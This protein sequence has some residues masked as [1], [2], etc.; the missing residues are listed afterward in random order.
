MFFLY[1]NKTNFI[2]YITILYIKLGNIYIKLHQNRKECIGIR[3]N[4]KFIKISKYSKNIFNC[5]NFFEL[6]PLYINLFS[7]DICIGQIFFGASFTIYIFDSD[8]VW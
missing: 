5:P 1:I 4:G 8:L 2:L 7:S 6:L 3:F